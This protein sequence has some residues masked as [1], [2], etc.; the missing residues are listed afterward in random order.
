MMGSGK[1]CFGLTCLRPACFPVIRAGAER[2]LPLRLG[3][4]LGV[5]PLETRPT[6]SGTPSTIEPWYVEGGLTAWHLGTLYR[7]DLSG[8]VSD[9]MSMRWSSTEDTISR[10]ART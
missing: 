4:S 8:A 1:Q 3:R 5:R 6:S 10:K 9:R 7:L 2:R